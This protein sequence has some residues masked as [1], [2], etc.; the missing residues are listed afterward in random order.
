MLVSNLSSLK[1][2]YEMPCIKYN[3]T[4]DI[5]LIYYTKEIYFCRRHCSRRGIISSEISP[6]LLKVL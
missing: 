6:K 4:V 5:K 2:N 1:K 3:I